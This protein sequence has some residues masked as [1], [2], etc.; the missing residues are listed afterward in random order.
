[1]K[2]KRLGWLWGPAAVLA[3]GFW[4]LR[5]V[6]AGAFE[7]GDRWLIAWYLVLLGAV[8]LG[9]GLL[10]FLFQEKKRDWTL[11]R[12]YPFAGLT[13]GLFYLFVLPPLS[14]PDEISHYISAYQLS[15]HML[16]EEANYQ[17][18]H[19]LV[20]A[21]DWFLEDTWGAYV[22]EDGEG[23]W[24][25][26][27]KEE[28]G[29]RLGDKKSSSQASVLGQTLTEETYSLI[30]DVGTGALQTPQEQAL[31][32]EKLL[33][34]SPYPPVVTTPLAYVPQAIGI[35]LARLLELDS[36]WLAYLGRLFNLLFFVAVTWLSMKRLPMGREV[37]FGVA[38]LPMTLHLS[39]SFS[40][41]VMILACMFYFTSICLD[42][43]YRRERVRPLD[44][45]F[46]ALLMAVA[47]PCKMVYAV[48]M[49]LCLLIPVKQFGGWARWG[50]SAVIVA[51]AFVLSMVLVNGQTIVQ[52][53]AAG[54]E[55]VVPWSQ[56]AGYSLTL[57]LHQPMRL[58]QMFYNTLV[59]MG[60]QYH[61]T[62]IGGMMGNLDPVLSVPYAASALL[63][64][65]LILLAL[66]KPGETAEL[67]GGRRLWVFGVC[68]GCFGAILG[69]ML[70][71]WTP[72]SSPYIQGV[73]GRY[74]LP[75]LPVLL[76]ACKNDCLVLTKDRNRSIL[77][78]MYCVNGYAL[79]RLFATVSMRI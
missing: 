78:L 65:C 61:L 71:A 35:S 37:L 46:M 39:A 28:D 54:E 59:T 29:K 43:A 41:D 64:G 27:E 52:Y 45:V 76:M 9:A 74:F 34:V 55:A 66:K 44:V 73:Q 53:A 12:I 2:E 40:Y 31:S 20:R 70:I 21:E 77:Y 3:F 8:L 13:L 26:A 14:A 4:H 36:L 42:L 51:A 58:L 68:L 6:Q 18:G 60:E 30:H 62:M 5:E 25:K 24:K 22:Y 38:M 17:T 7:S 1:M 79:L 48:M 69:S 63:T 47:G 75:F 15:S 23:L 32:G 56:E 10:G 49:G 19:V 11:T 67:K 16:G 57:L 50:V 33:A 72:L